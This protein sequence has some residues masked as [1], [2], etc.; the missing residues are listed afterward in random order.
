[1]RGIASYKALQRDTVTG[2]R[3]VLLLLIEAEKRLILAVDEMAAGGL[4]WRTHLRHVR[5]ILTELMVGLDDQHGDPE[6]VAR[7]R[8]IYIWSVSELGQASVEHDPNRIQGV[9]RAIRPLREAWEK[10]VDGVVV[11][12]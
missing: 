11:A 12:P 4:E 10:V 3:L 1:M 6:L 2:P 8:N 5:Q 9:A 7:L